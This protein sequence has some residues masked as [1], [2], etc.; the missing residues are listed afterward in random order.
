MA[1]TGRPPSIHPTQYA[2]LRRL[3]QDHPQATLAELAQAW[4]EFAGCDAPSTV[5]LAKTLRL[6]GLQRQRP[7]AAPAQRAA[8]APRYGYTQRHRDTASHAALTDA[9]WAL[10]RDL[11]EPASGARGRPAL[12]DHPEHPLRLI[13][14]SIHRWRIND[15]T[16]VAAA[17]RALA[18]EIRIAGAQPNYLFKQEGI[19]GEGIPTGDPAQ[20]VIAKLHLPDAHR[21]ATG[22]N[23]LIAVIDSG[24]GKVLAGPEIH[25]RGF[26]E[27]EAVFESILPQLTAALEEAAS[28]GSVDTHQLQQV[29]RRVVGRFVSNRLRRRPMIIPVVVEA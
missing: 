22:Q 12:H 7:P 16:S 4:A 19:E 25:A 29:M 21:V 11:F 5:T 27:D 2:A 13:G 3:V 15:G 23:V 24:T 10:A 6:A 1:K 26:A 20:Y 9:E 28:T 8:G 18:G 14:R 17:I